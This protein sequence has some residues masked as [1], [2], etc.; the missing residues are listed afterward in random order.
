[1]VRD[2]GRLAHA[3]GLAF[4]MPDPFPANSLKA[5][6]LARIGC[7]EGW[8]G[9]FSKAV[10]EAE[11]SQGADIASEDVLREILDRHG[12]DGAALLARTSAPEAKE[13]LREVTSEAERRFWRAELCD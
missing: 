4:R 11:F 13:R 12:L 3:R 8:V 9:P 2:V 10:F 1:M 5:A 6:R 7:E